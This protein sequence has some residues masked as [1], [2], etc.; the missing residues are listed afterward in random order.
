MQQTESPFASKAFTFHR[1]PFLY[2][3]DPIFNSGPVHERYR[4]LIEQLRSII[5]SQFSGSKAT[6]ATNHRN[7]TVSLH[8]VGAEKRPVYFVRY[9]VRTHNGSRH[10]FPFAFD[11]VQR[12]RECIQFL[13]MKNPAFA[14]IRERFREDVLVDALSSLLTERMRNAMTTSKVQ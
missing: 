14:T 5:D 6:F 1:T 3:H 7:L 13:V 2:S 4:Q 11:D 8:H 10:M 9:A 12:L